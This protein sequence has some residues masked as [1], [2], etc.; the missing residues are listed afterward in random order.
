MQP[1]IKFR[2]IRG[3]EMLDNNK[4]I[5]VYG[6]SNI[7]LENIKELGY[8]IVEIT[9]EMCEMTLMDVLMGAKFEI[10]NNNIID[11]K[12]I[13]YNNL[14]EEELRKSIKDTRTKIKDGILAVVTPQSI[15]WKI[16]YL[17]K[18][19]KEEKEWYSKVRK[20]R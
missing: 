16:N 11:E 12:V 19:L 7:E 20:E 15:N 14:S 13:L 5:L 18:H 9:T 2:Y 6:L 3:V 17:I 10:F 4:C 1:Y 8:K